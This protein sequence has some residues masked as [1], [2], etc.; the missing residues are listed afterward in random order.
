MYRVII[1]IF[2]TMHWY[3]TTISLGS[4]HTIRLCQLK[5]WP[6]FPGYGFNLHA[7]KGKSAQFIG[8]IDPKSPAEAAGLREGDRIMEVNG[9]SVVNETHSEV[10]KRIKTDPKQV[11]ILFYKKKIVFLL[12]GFMYWLIIEIIIFF[13]ASNNFITNS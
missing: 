1:V 11:N 6:D 8:K 2:V 12:I 5:I 3:F 4:S 9:V 7:E 10:V 13:L